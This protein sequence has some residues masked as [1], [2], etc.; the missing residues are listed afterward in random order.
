MKILRL[1]SGWSSSEDMEKLDIKCIKTVE[2][3]IQYE[4][5]G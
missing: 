2:N 5:N 4:K 1:K 3:D